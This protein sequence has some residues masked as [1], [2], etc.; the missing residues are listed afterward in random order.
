MR[1]A[2]RLSIGIVKRR[3]GVG[4]RVAPSSSSSS[5]VGHPIPGHVSRGEE[6]GFLPSLAPSHLVG[7]QVEKRC[8]QLSPVRCLKERGTEICVVNV[9]LRGVR[10]EWILKRARACN[11]AEE[12]NLDGEVYAVRID[13]FFRSCTTGG[14]K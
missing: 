6:G 7:G 1:V 11:C 3:R 14:S 12:G 9:L 2:S 13:M 10:L 8:L 4:F 5:A